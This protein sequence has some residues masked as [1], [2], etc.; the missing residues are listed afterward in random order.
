MLPNSA[1]PE[2]TFSFFGLTHTKHRNRLDPGKVHNIAIVRN[3]LQKRHIALGLISPRKQRHFSLADD[4]EDSREENADESEAGAVIGDRRNLDFNTLAEELINLA[5]NEDTTDEDSE[6]PAATATSA[7]PVLLASAIV[8]DPRMRIPA[9]K[10]IRLE[11]L[12]L[13]PPGGS[14]ADELEFFWKG[15]RD[16]LD[17]E[18]ETLGVGMES[19]AGDPTSS[20]NSV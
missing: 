16:S 20:V 9:Y 19:G 2:R 8:I 18:E 10:K 5:E 11:H 13:Y 17:E 12:F 7:A 4:A 1:G 14:P 15:G 3:D 6:P